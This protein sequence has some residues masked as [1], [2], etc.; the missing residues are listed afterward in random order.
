MQSLDLEL[1][2]PHWRTHSR[3]TLWGRGNWVA[4]AQDL[5]GRVLAWATFTVVPPG[6]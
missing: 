4:E 1:G 2:G 5:N 6:S 3:K